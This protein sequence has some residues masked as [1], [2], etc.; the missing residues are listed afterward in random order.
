MF[1]VLTPQLKAAESGL[2]GYWTF[3][4]GSGTIAN[5]SSGNGNTGTMNGAQWVEGIKGKALKFDGSSY[6]KVSD[7]PSLDLSGYSMAVEFWVKLGLNWCP[8]INHSNLLIYDK[9]DAY[10][11]SF[12]ASSGALRFN[13][14]YVPVRQTP[15][16]VKND[17]TAD[18]WYFIAE[19]YDEPF[20][21]I[22]VNGVLDHSDLVSDPI[23]QS[24]F[25]FYIG[26][27][28]LLQDPPWFNGII[29]EFAIYNYAR[30]SEEILNDYN[31]VTPP[32][33][34]GYW[35][36]D[37]TSGTTAHDSSGNSND[38][39]VYSATWTV[40]KIDNALNFNGANSWVSIPSSNSLSGVS[41]LTLQAWIKPDT[42]STNPQMKQIVGKSSGVP[43]YNDEYGLELVGGAVRFYVSGA[44]S[45][46][47]MRDTANVI[48]TGQWYFVAGT[49]DGQNYTIYVNG[50]VVASG[51]SSAGSSTITSH[52]VEIGRLDAWSYTYFDGIIDE[53]KIYNHARSSEEILNDYFS[54]ANKWAAVI[55]INAYDSF[56]NR[57]GAA[58]SATQMYNALTENFGFSSDHIN[59]Y[60]GALT[61]DIFDIFDD[62]SCQKVNETL[63]WLDQVA[64]P[65]DTVLFYYAGHGYRDVSGREYLAA[66]DDTQRMIRD[67]A[68]ARALNKIDCK[69]LIVILDMSYAGG[70][71]RD[72]SQPSDV[73]LDVSGNPADN[74]IVLT[75]CGEVTQENEDTQALMSEW[76][77]AFSHFLIDGFRYDENGD[78]KTSLE[79][80]FR[81][82]KSKFPLYELEGKRPILQQPQIYDGFPAFGDSSREFILGNVVTEQ[83]VAI[84]I[85][86]F[87]AQCPVQLHVYNSA[88]KHVGLDSSGQVEIGFEATYQ[89]IGESKLVAVPSSTD[90]YT[91][92]LVGTEEGSYNLTVTKFD[93]GKIVATTSQTGTTNVGR[94]EEYVTSG[95]VD[96]LVLR[97]ARLFG[98]S[99][100][101]WPILGVLIVAGVCIVV[102]PTWLIWRR[103]HQR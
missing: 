46:L 35:N 103:K 21:K 28:S 26:A 60:A 18:T 82:A 79:E 22:Y 48:S 63:D 19:V 45:N 39:T 33:L 43:Q 37:E 74:R 56:E 92:K 99:W 67:D 40:G 49:W 78:G 15:E 10:T 30:S 86:M 55:G 4:E 75:A 11:S 85:T 72:A 1:S 24:G 20:I 51:T 7:S 71:I 69:T 14:A 16:T 31:A 61:D 53:V 87:W 84:P 77:M 23:P 62:I 36:L 89:E 95:A 25:D 102:V 96:L 42:L 8:G 5:D 65:Q 83:A 73:A 17:W 2:I 100:L 76:E 93:D 38:G 12:I 68:L 9:G 97:P 90:A 29:D 13:L 80:A 81:Y 27:Q 91:V 57:W 70:F 41:Q 44:S 52:P 3:D 34:V 94:T 58:E 101:T 59:N 47:F 54:S 50:E 88:G 98:I 32:A 6:V 66:H 64:G